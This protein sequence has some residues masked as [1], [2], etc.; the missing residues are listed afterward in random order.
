MVSLSLPAM[1]T[2]QLPVNHAVTRSY[3]PTTSRCSP[4][5]TPL[6]YFLGQRFLLPLYFRKISVSGQENLPH[7]GPV[8]LAPTHRARWDSLVL[9]LA[10]GRPVTGR[11]L[12]F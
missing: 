9:P 2:L 8:I 1:P 6:A 11:D 3:K 10:A 12:R 7:S 4:F 5:L